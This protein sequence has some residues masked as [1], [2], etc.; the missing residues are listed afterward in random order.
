MGKTVLVLGASGLFGGHVAK[1]FAAAGWQ[2]KTCR[3]GTDM[4]AAAQ[5]VDVIVNGLNPPKY[6]D[7]DRIIPATTRQAIAAAAASA[8]TLWVPGNV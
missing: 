7:W 4:D 8:A 5:G 2:V 6:H 3:R 1:A